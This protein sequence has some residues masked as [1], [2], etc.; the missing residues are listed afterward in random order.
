M[1]QKRLI[2]SIVDII[3]IIDCC[4]LSITSLIDS[5]GNIVDIIDHDFLIF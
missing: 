1:I 3:N 4:P 5:F 2:L